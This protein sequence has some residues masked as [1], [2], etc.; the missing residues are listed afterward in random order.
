MTEEQR[1]GDH[2]IKVINLINDS[3]DRCLALAKN[4]GLC[5]VCGHDPCACGTAHMGEVE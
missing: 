3:L 5:A 4:Q 1:I 2:I